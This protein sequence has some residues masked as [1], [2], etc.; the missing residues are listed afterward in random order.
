MRH[1]LL[2]VGLALLAGCSNS[3]GGGTQWTGTDEVRP[4]ST[5]PGLT[6]VSLFGDHLNDL[7][8]R[9]FDMM[10]GTS[11]GVRV[12]VLANTRR[13]NVSAGDESKGKLFGPNTQDWSKSSFAAVPFTGGPLL[14]LHRQDDPTYV[15]LE[16]HEGDCWQD[17]V[18]FFQKFRSSHLIGTYAVV[19]SIE[20]AFNPNG[21]MD[22]E[23]AK[24]RVTVYVLRKA[25]EPTTGFAGVFAPVEFA[26]LMATQI[27]KASCHPADMTADYQHLVQNAE[28]PA[29]ETRRRSD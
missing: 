24:T 11:M 16:V 14:R 4:I 5:N 18:Q 28:V 25:E 13:L 29:N 12:T 20:Q 9:S 3:T 1:W 8:F 6:P 27:P 22:M 2:G 15:D 26:F 10:T 19:V 21:Y 7:I 23:G 17:D